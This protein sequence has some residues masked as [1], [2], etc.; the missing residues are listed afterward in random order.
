M[1]RKPQ[2]PKRVRRTRGSK[3]P[4]EPTRTPCPDSPDK[5]PYRSPK[6]AEI[7]MLKAQKLAEPGQEVPRRAYECTGCF[8]WHL[9]HLERWVRD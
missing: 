9:T 6:A 8:C 5:T 3:G 2:R 7:A 1:F 4:D